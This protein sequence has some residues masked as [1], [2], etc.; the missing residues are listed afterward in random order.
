MMDTK[1]I[2]QAAKILIGGGTVVF[3]T[4]TLYGLAAIA[5]N[6][7]AVRKVYAIKRRPP[8]KLLP[9]VV[10]SFAQA[11]KYFIFSRQELVLARRFWPGPFSLVLKTRSKK[12]A[13]AM[14]GDRVAVRYSANGIA[15]RLTLLAGTPVT[16]T[17]AN[18]SGKPGCFTIL[19]V[20]RQLGSA[21]GSRVLHV[22]PDMFLNGGTLKR[23]YPSTIVRVQRGR[24]AVLR[25]GK[26]SAQALERI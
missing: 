16:A 4:E 3:P 26:I 13:V 23:S 5:T 24:V 20:K 25:K 9:V 8:E 7:T 18:I 10:G 19:A 15:T 6:K 11:R 14:G 22:H 2:K 17:S 12:L 1:E 21:S